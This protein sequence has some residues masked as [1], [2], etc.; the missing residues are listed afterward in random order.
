MPPDDLTEITAKVTATPHESTRLWPAL[1][2]LLR[3]RI[4]AGLVTVIPIWVTYIVVKFVFDLMKSVTEPI[5]GRVNDI[6][7]DMYPKLVPQLVS[8]YVD[9]S[10]PIMAVM[11]TLFLLYM[12]GLMTASVVG[13]R[14]LFIVD[15]TMGKVPFVKSIY[16]ATKQI[17]VTLGGGAS[18]NFKRVVLVEFP[19]PGM[20]CIGFLTAV[21]K[22]VDTGRDMATIFISTTPNPTTGYMQILPLDEVSETGWTVEE[23]VKLLMSGGILSPPTVPFDKIHPVKMTPQELEVVTSREDESLPSRIGPL[24]AE[25]DKT[26]DDKD[27]GA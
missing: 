10:V 6:L 1:R 17:M 14:M 24:E 25:T 18:V 9:Y 12:L 26:D 16:N 19:R 23:A 7:L 2:R 13:R 21:L 5:A 3:T 8:R 15:V 22:D 20:K 4:V 11:M 27:M